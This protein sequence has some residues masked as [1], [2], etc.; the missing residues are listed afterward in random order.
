MRTAMRSII[1]LLLSS[2]PGAS[3]AGDKVPPQRGTARQ[4]SPTE[5]EFPALPCPDN[6]VPHGTYCLQRRMSGI[7]KVCRYWRIQYE[8][9]DYMRAGIEL[10]SDCPSG[11]ICQSIMP[12]KRGLWTVYQNRPRPQIECVPKPS[13][14]PRPLPRPRPRPLKRHRHVVDIA[15][16]AGLDAVAAGV[17]ASDFDM[18]TRV[19]PPASRRRRRRRPVPIMATPQQQHDSTSDP[20]PSL[21]TSVDSPFWA[22]VHTSTRV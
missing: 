8:L 20:G 5:V 3:P 4:V 18:P 22:T 2:V 17:L 13:A 12:D 11:T 14:P 7:R 19:P 6:M 21:P 1:W 10:I 15:D 16:E 9:V